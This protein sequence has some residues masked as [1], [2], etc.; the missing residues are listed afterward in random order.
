[1]LQ[2]L[3]RILS[4][5][6]RLSSHG[7]SIPRRKLVQI[8]V[9]SRLII[10]M[11]M[12]TSCWLFPDHNP[13]DDVL[14]FPLRFFQGSCFC[15]QGQACDD[16]E[17]WQQDQHPLPTIFPT[18]CA[19]TETH[20]AP[21]VV[22]ARVY[23]FFL[24]PT[25]RWDAAR[26]LDLAVVPSR[27]EL[28]RHCDDDCQRLAEQAHAFFPLFPLVVRAM[29]RALTQLVPPLLLPPT[30]EGVVA[31][32]AVLVNNMLCFVGAALAL[33][34][35]TL[36][37]TRRHLEAMP[38]RAERK[39]EPRV[40][41]HV[42]WQVF[43]LFCIN[44]ASVFFTAAYSESLFACCHMGGH[45]LL[46]QAMRQPAKLSSLAL[47]VAAISMWMAASYTRSNGAINAAWLA[48]LGI[49]WACQQASTGHHG[50]AVKGLIV[51]LVGGILVT[52]PVAWHDAAG[53]QRLCPPDD[54]SRILPGWCSNAKGFSLYGYV[55]HQHWN[56]G[57]FRYY[58]PKKIPNFI[59]AAPMLGMGMGAV[60]QWIQT[61]YRH[62]FW[63]SQAP[64]GGNAIVSTIP[65]AISALRAWVPF[66]R[67]VS[68]SKYHQDVNVVLFMGPLLLGHYAILAAAC[69]VGLTVAHVEISTRMICSTC[70][71][72][73]W[74]MALCCHDVPQKMT[75][76]WG[77]GVV[78]PYCLLY[79]LLGVVMHPNWLPWT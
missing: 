44:P 18:K 30:Y 32:A 61:S 13:G 48:L 39:L 43:I 70:P 33:H 28:P 73:Y 16:Q 53:Y 25:T 7:P 75:P 14:R 62:Y 15:L 5:E 36:S 10:L 6:E 12:A 78:V 27:R 51:C 41:T 29:A 37:L 52:L 4:A 69:L 45:A 35:M 2:A 71:A 21:A 67:P 47:T 40:G 11:A 49:G 22:T 65:W 46:L 56:V 63:E 58:T 17:A 26:F 42:A 9:L 66:D 24:T 23:E 34:D 76:V 55:Q 77:R 64:R 79:I 74:Y 31:L 20:R 38:D 8:A 68:S 72:I 57:W 1:M 59:L 50:K 3:E 19:D 54:E 60:V